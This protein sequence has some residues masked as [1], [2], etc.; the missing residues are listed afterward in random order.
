M[1]GLCLVWTSE[2]EVVLKDSCA[3]VS[4]YFPSFSFLSSLF[5]GAH[6]LLYNILAWD[7]TNRKARQTLERQARKNNN[8]NSAESERG[9]MDGYVRGL[10]QVVCGE[11]SRPMSPHPMDGRALT[12]CAVV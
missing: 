7:E 3:W 9:A 5:S 4:G 6:T 2:S 8:N 10:V 12:T 11:W 1:D